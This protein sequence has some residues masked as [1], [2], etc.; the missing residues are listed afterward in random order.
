MWIQLRTMC[1]SHS[2]L[3][4]CCLSTLF[5]SDTFAKIRDTVILSIN[6]PFL[7]LILVLFSLSSSFPLPPC[8]YFLL[9]ISLLSVFERGV[10]HLRPLW[11]ALGEH[12][13]IIL[14]GPA[15]QLGDTQLPHRS[16]GSVHPAAQAVNQ[17]GIAV[18]VGPLRLEPVCLSLRHWQR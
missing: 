16:R 10:C 5:V 6:C 3:L 12:A 4:I 1:L 9:A 11:Q 7:V 8:Y 14:W 2:Y 17:R 15:H 18:T 13:D